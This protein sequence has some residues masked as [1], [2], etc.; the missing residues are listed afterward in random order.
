ML[1][2]RARESFLLDFVSQFVSTLALEVVGMLHDH[3]TT[4]SIP[5]SIRT[6][7]GC[8]SG[9]SLGVY[10]LRRSQAY[11]HSSSS[12]SKK[13]CRIRPIPVV[14]CWTKPHG[15]CSFAADGQT[16]TYLRIHYSYLRIAPCLRVGESLVSH[17]FVYPAGRSYPP[18]YYVPCPIRCTFIL[19]HRLLKAGQ[20]YEVGLELDMPTTYTN[21]RVG[22]FM[23]S[24]SS[25]ST[26]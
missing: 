1:I 15:K 22:V 10:S 11:A 2:W 12:Q 17:S 3:F 14:S 4:R 21:R 9:M 8:C 6:S 5:H 18:C 13:S 7:S 20:H 16:L 19:V 23:V 25:S 24:V 26:L